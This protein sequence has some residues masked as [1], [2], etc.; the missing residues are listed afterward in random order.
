MGTF[1]WVGSHILT[2][3]GNTEFSGNDLMQWHMIK[4][5]REQGCSTLDLSGIEPFP[6]SPKMRSIYEFKSKWG[7]KQ[8]DYDEFTIYPNNLKSRLHRYLIEN[9]G[10]NLKA[11]DRS[12]RGVK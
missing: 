4:W 11:I 9:I 8:I 12:V 6:S 2:T 5:G 1:S 3:V 10:P 7:G